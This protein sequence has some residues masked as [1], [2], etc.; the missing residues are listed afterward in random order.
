MKF[1]EKLI[2]LRKQSGMSQEEL[3][4]KL[5]VTRQTVSKWELGQSKPDMEKLIEISKLFNIPIGNL[6][7]E[8]DSIEDEPIRENGEKK[9]NNSLRNALIAAGVFIIILF[10]IRLIFTGIVLNQFNKLGLAGEDTAKTFISIFFDIMGKAEEMERKSMLENERA[11]ERRNNTTN[12]ETNKDMLYNTIDEIPEMLNRIED[13]LENRN[14]NNDI[15]SSSEMINEK[16]N[17]IMSNFQNWN[18]DLVP[19][20]ETSEN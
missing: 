17:D 4:E 10:I 1:E 19:S 14:S 2:K 11:R 5:D 18:L 12:E 8:N 20:P 9:G 16:M 15:Q 13:R 6:T 7:D 3:A